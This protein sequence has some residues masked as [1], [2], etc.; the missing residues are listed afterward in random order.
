MAK[1]TSRPAPKKAAVPVAARSR[2]PAWLPGTLLVLVTMLAYLPVWHAGFI[3]DDDAF[4]TDNPL[5][6]AP[7][8]LYQFWCTTNA[9]D[10]FPM[11]S[12]TLWLEW[13]LWGMNAVGYHVVNVLLHATS[14][15][16]LWRVLVRLKIPGGW[17]AAAIFAVHPV[18]AESVVWIAERKNT[19]TMFFYAWVLFGYLRFEDT[20]RKL[21]YGLGLGAFALALLSKTAVTPL[22]FVLLGLAWWRRGLITRRDVWRVLPFFIMAGL[23]G[24][25]TVWF[26]YHRA[27][28]HDIVRTDNFY[29]RLAGT[30]WAI[31]FYL[32]KALWPQNLI[33]VYP[34]W[35]IEATKPLAYLPDLLLMAVVAVCWHYRRRWGRPIFFALG[36]FVVMLLPVLGFLNIYFMRYSLVADHWQYFS[37]LAPIT[38]M[39]AGLT[40]AW[41]SWGKA[42]LCLG[43]VVG[44]ALVFTLGALTWKQSHIY[45][46]VETLWQDTLTKNPACWLAHNNLGEFLD[47]HNQTDAAFSQFQE[48]I[49]LQP[50]SAEAHNNLGKILNQQGQTD[51]AIS[52]IQTALRLKPDFADAHNN[53]G[54]ILTKQDQN[55]A[56]ISQFQ[57]AIRLKPDH[58][59][60]HNNLGIVLA[61]QNQNDAAIS[62][63]REAIRLNP[64]Y[65]EAHNNLGS[66]LFG[67][68]Q[69]DA[70]ISQYQQAI[71]LNHD[72]A[73]AYYNLGFALGKKDQNGAAA[74]Q[75]Q[76]VIRLKPDD[77]DA[78]Y[79]LGIALDKLGRNDEAIREFQETIRQNPDAPD[80]HNHLGVALAR[81]GQ[82]AEAIHQ[83]QEAIHLKPDFTEANYNLG[84][85]LFNDGQTD[86]AI[87]QFKETIRLKPDYADAHNNLGVALMQQNQIDAAISQ[88]QEAIRLKPD[89]TSARDNLTKA[90]EQKNKSSM[91][92]SDP[93]KP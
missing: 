27:I 6:K 85:A 82:T 57:E 87:S 86:A 43:I 56:A 22:P 77:T 51:A 10:Y 65:A 48:A 30:G 3:W 45:A 2:Y 47:K 33:F 66:A 32:G 69:T 1:K 39:A 36:Y 4:L 16:L 31:W 53:L 81:K 29:S 62:Q 54:V 18:N 55:D 28:G 70:A 93:G 19:L 64:D 92:I 67:Q 83:F 68:G 50:D 12:T 78:H 49:R 72:I 34:R 52:Q 38:L 14:S 60:A 91:Q 61:K 89:Y 17:L 84:K 25:I 24:L 88:F 26:Q 37:I 80:A 11:T 15:V 79:Y 21:W 8:G 13:R 42:N 5:I 58:A 90:L 20:G 46:N 71:R 35:N 9:P 76:E 59:E 73:E 74:S 63:F 44:G 23:L 40:V 7:D 41:K 75:F